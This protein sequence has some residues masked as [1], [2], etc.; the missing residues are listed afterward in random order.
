MPLS[1][2]D[3]VAG[4][5]GVLSLVEELATVSRVDVVS[6][7]SVVWCPPD[8]SV[9]FLLS[10]VV[11]SGGGGLSVATLSVAV[12]VVSRVDVLR[13]VISCVV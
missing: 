13:V 11:L 12:V 2:S 7:D 8:T 9:V 1:L 10:D 5:G 3:L 6:L 4:G